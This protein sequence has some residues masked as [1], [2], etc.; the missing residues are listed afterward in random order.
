MGG[1][2]LSGQWVVLTGAS[3][4]IGL[5]AVPRFAAAGAR[6]AL[7][8]RDDERTGRGRALGRWLESGHEPAA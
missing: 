5:A 3:S 8:A 1:P 4:G 6:L 2:S 7:V